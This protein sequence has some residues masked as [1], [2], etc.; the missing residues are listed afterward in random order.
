MNK[1]NSVK[2]LKEV[3]EIT[4]IIKLIFESKK[5]ILFFTAVIFIL[6][7]LFHIN[8]PNNYEIKINFR[9]TENSK[10]FKFSKLNEAFKFRELNSIFNNS[11]NFKNQNDLETSLIFIDKKKIFDYFIHTFNE[12]KYLITILEKPEYQETLKKANI[13]VFSKANS[14]IIEKPIN[15]QNSYKLVLFW[16]DNKKSI[17]LAE[18]IFFS[19]LTTVKKKLIDELNFKLKR[20]NEDYIFRTKEIENLNKIILDGT[21]NKIKNKLIFLEEQLKIAELLGLE[22][23]NLDLEESINIYQD[24]N[25]F[26]TYNPD[27]PYYLR[28]IKSIKQEISNLRNRQ[29]DNYALSDDRLSKLYEDLIYYKFQ[30]ENFTEV[31]SSNIKILQNTDPTNWLDYNF[32]LLEIKNTKN[33]QILLILSIFVGLIFSTFFVLVFQS[34][35][36][37]LRNVY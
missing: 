14:F 2:E 28:G 1:K 15:D 29:I 18:D 24:N 17:I 5:T 19:I 33:T 8:T 6:T 31:I 23:S 22:G 27:S 34:I 10:F 25:E 32:N 36:K 26:F 12:K 13:D 9:E 11:P 16:P 3:S 4:L 7:Y 20:I 37:E 35:R 21:K 30:H